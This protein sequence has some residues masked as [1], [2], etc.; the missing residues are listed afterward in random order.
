MLDIIAE[1]KAEA[2]RDIL[3]AKA[4]IEVAESIERKFLERES[5]EAEASLD[6]EPTVE[7]ETDAEVEES[8]FGNI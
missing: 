2:E 3:V 1:I 4:K 5:N 8:E 6:V 7:T